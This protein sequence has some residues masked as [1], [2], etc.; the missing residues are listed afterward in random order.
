[1]RCGIDARAEFGIVE[2]AVKHSAELARAALPVRRGA[3]VAAV[4]PAVAGV[5]GRR[6]DI[7]G[8]RQPDRRAAMVQAPTPGA[9]GDQDQAEATGAERRTRGP[10]SW[11]IVPRRF[12]RMARGPDTRRPPPF[13][14]RRS[15]SGNRE[16]RHRRPARR[17]SPR[18]L[19]RR[20]QRA[21]S[22]AAP[23]RY[24]PQ[25]GS[26]NL[27]TTFFSPTL[28]KITISLSPSTV[29]TTPLPNFSLR[30]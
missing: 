27:A 1:M 9:V 25:A 22:W 8:L 15:P 29:L 10:P 26:T 12:D 3:A 28:S 7:T 11:R 6:R 19:R 17:R 4:A 24:A 13:A 2:Q 18:S 5:F 30:M 14:R 23:F 20:W 21:P 16:S